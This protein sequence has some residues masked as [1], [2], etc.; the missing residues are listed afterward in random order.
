MQLLKFTWP[1]IHLIDFTFSIIM[2][3]LPPRIDL[4]SHGSDK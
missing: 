2:G 1:T 4:A 3:E